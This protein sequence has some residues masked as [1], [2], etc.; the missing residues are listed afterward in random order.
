M[1]QLDDVTIV[2]SGTVMDQF[3]GRHLWAA[4]H[5]AR[6]AHTLE[7]AAQQ[8][9]TPES[10]YDVVSYNVIAAILL[11]VAA[12]ESWIGDITAVPS[13]AQYFPGVPDDFIDKVRGLSNAQ[14]KVSQL[15]EK[16]GRPAL[17][18]TIDPDRE[19]ADLISLRNKIVHFGAEPLN[20]RPEH[21][22]VERRVAGR[23]GRSPLLGSDAPLFPTAFASY[24]SAKWAVMTARL[25]IEWMG[26]D[27]GWPIA[28]ITKSVHSAKLDL[29]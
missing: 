22:E 21:D 8:T 4:A 9:E 17:D 24:A 10:A 19:L 11:A 15:R 12:V 16:L 27:L 28:F 20:Q 29:P 3:G 25:F 23:F 13:R 5:F 1:A 18:K 26:S 6:Q 2:S 7:E 14:T